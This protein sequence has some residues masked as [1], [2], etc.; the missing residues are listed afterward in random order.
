MKKISFILLC[1]SFHYGFS[2]NVNALKL[3]E[4]L[5]G[6][7]I[8]QTIESVKSMSLDTLNIGNQIKELKTALSKVYDKEYTEEEI[9]SLITFYK[10]AAGKK[11]LV[12]QVLIDGKVTDKIYKWEAKVQGIELPED[13][14]ELAVIEP[15]N[16]IINPIGLENQVIRKGIAPKKELPK[17][18][19]LQD[20]KKL[21]EKDINVIHDSQFLAKLLDIEE[22]VNPALDIEDVLP[23]M[24]IKKKD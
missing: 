7:Q 2:Q 3:V 12:S 4:L 5:H 24:E 11:M 22:L 1:F 20:L 19:T 9:Q 16:D 15:I 10:S 8:E 18:N 13:N 23:E 17:V 21:I 6:K 14:D